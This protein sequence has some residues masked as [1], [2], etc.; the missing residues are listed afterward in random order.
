LLEEEAEAEVVVSMMDLQYT[1]GKMLSSGCM[2]HIQ[3]GGLDI[4]D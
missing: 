4:V 1:V 3:K 2:Q